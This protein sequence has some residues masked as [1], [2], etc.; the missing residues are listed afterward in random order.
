MDNNNNH[1]QEKH[2]SRVEL[3]DTPK[4][5]KKPKRSLF[6]RKGKQTAATGPI[7]GSQTEGNANRTSR[8]SLKK[9][10]QPKR[11]KKPRGKKNGRIYKIVLGILLGIL[12]IMI[13]IFAIR[14]DRKSVV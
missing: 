7:S 14:Q 10:G 6:S 5:R 12:A 11:P 9:A 4:S 1:D 2:L 13:I 8:T 3:Y